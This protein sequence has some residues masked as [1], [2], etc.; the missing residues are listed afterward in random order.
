MVMSLWTILLPEA[1]QN[2]E[3]LALAAKVTY[4]VDKTLSVRIFPVGPYVPHG[5]QNDIIGHFL[6][7]PPIFHSPAI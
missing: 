6:Y 4:E 1:L 5:K 2:P 7:T 3:V